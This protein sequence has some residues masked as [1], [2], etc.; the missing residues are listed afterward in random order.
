MKEQ[1]DLT[2]SISPLPLM[3]QTYFNSEVTKNT[4]YAKSVFLRGIRSIP[5]DKQFWLD[6]IAWN[7]GF[8]PSERANWIEMMKKK[9]VIAET[10]LSGAAIDETA[11]I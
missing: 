5:Y 10:D 2:E 7:E 3:W 1:S 11:K 4:E 6:G 8:S 9:G